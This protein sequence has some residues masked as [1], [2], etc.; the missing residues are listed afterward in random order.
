MSLPKEAEQN[1]TTPSYR[2]L[3]SQKERERER[4]RCNNEE[5]VC[6]C[7]C[8]GPYLHPHWAPDI[9]WWAHVEVRRLSRRRWEVEPSGRYA[10]STHNFLSFTTFITTIFSNWTQVWSVCLFLKCLQQQ[11]NKDTSGVKESVLTWTLLQDILKNRTKELLLLLNF[12]SNLWIKWFSW[13]SLSLLHTHTLS[14]SVLF[15]SS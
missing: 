6:V 8:V 3:E 13:D 10:T 12:E 15:M 4:E 14:K 7:V 5:H 1:R 11:G 9:E 2:P